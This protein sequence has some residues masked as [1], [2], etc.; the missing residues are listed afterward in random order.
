[1]ILDEEKIDRIKKLLKFHQK[2]LTISEISARL[3]INRNSVA[4]YLEILFITGQVTVTHFG[5]AKVYSLTQRIPVS[6]MIR[7][8]SDFIIVLDDT[9]HVVDINENCARFF[10]LVRQ[11]MVGRDCRQTGN[12]I[13]SGFLMKCISMHPHSGTEATFEIQLSSA[14]KESVFRCRAVPTIFEDGNSGRLFILE[15]VTAQ[16]E[17]ELRLKES[18]AK[19]RAIVEGQTELI[20]RWLPD[21]T[22]TYVNE[23][24]NR[25]FGK[26]G[27]F[28]IGKVFMPLISR[29]GRTVAPRYT[30][31]QGRMITTYEHRV[32][33]PN[34][35]I[36]W[37]QWVDRA[38]ALN[39]GTII[40][41]QSVGRDITD[42]KRIEG[43]IREYV[44]GMEYLSQAALRLHTA[45][46]GE[47]LFSLIAHGIKGFV[48]DATVCVFSYNPLT[49]RLDLRSV[50]NQEDRSRLGGMV[51]FPGLSPD[52]ILARQCFQKEKFSYPVSMPPSEEGLLT[53]QLPDTTFS[54]GLAWQD[55]PFG[56]V[57]I[58]QKRNGSLDNETIIETYIRLASVA[59][60][61]RM[62]EDELVKSREQFRSIADFSPF[63]ISLMDKEGAFLYVNRR[64]TEFF[65]YSLDDMDKRHKWREKVYPDPKYR[66]MVI[67]TLVK[68][69]EKTVYGE[70]VPRVFSVVCKDGSV[71]SVLFRPVMMSDGSCFVMYDEP[72][73]NPMKSP[74][75]S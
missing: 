55:R 58:I 10:S 67:G 18:E 4:K 70:T 3:K 41:Y 36:R 73:M 47:D 1:M 42:Q 44:F 23:A 49:H 48:P 53:T 13:F 72:G 16:K 17:Y 38:I 45:R 71:K 43:K 11:E 68:D 6:D 20:C 39:D 57:C 74:E 46:E 64:F 7:F 66:A 26:E 75:A 28:F 32:L 65:G 54:I 2:G 24:F 12:P 30:S 15:D 61:R 25:Y 22:I 56:L 62:T 5:T 59:L 33:M 50:E 29:E 37:Q 14:E 40:E 69:R 34:G 63:P 8:S 9:D 27:F 21:G 31:Q 51:S 60:A 19:Y 52:E 35:I